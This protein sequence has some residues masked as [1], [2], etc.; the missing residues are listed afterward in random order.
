MTLFYV[1]GLWPKRINRD[2]THYDEYLKAHVGIDPA[3]LA[4]NCGITEN[5]VK[6]RQRKLG[7]R[8]LTSPNAYRKPRREP[9][10]SD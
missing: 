7:L 3:I 8:K 9:C 6:L 5:F 10:A 4:F 2:T 1:D